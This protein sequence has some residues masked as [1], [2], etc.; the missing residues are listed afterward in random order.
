MGRRPREN[1]MSCTATATFQNRLL[2]C[3]SPPLWEGHPW[4]PPAHYAHVD[5]Q[6]LIWFFDGD[7]AGGGSPV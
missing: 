6:T 3:E 5:G 2:H 4:H 7:E 1:R